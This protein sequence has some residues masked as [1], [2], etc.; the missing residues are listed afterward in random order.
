[1]KYYDFGKGDKYKLYSLHEL[2]KR[3]KK[4]NIE[5]GFYTVMSIIFLIVYII[6]VFK[7]LSLSFQL[8]ALTDYLIFIIVTVWTCIEYDMLD[9]I[10]N[11]RLRALN[12]GEESD[13]EVY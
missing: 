2:R 8:L 1:M 9:Q 12:L 6:T 4:R 10:I 5:A 3:N 11:L 13:Y 7:N